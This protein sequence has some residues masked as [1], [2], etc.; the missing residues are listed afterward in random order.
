MLDGAVQRPV[1]PRHQPLEETLV[2]S[3]GQGLGRKLNLHQ[4][5]D[6]RLPLLNLHHP[7]TPMETTPTHCALVTHKLHQPFL[8]PTTP[9]LPPLPPS[10]LPPPSLLH[11]LYLRHV[12]GP[13]SELSPSLDL[14]LEEGFGELCDRHAQKLGDLLSYGVIHQQGLV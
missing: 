1:D 5:R 3:L 11:L 4:E 2:E 10:S 6:I 9:S 7:I 13:N 14:G 12:L 8:P